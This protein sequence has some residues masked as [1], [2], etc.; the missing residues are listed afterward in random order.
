MMTLVGCVGIR[1]DLIR[2]LIIQSNIFV[3][4]PGHPEHQATVKSEITGSHGHGG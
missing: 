4:N 1:I 3:Q 2:H